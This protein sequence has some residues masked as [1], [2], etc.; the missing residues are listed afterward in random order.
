MEQ[1]KR[2]GIKGSKECFEERK[3]ERKKGRTEGAKGRK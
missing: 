3:E 2:K 1:E